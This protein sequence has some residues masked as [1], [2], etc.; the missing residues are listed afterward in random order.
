MTAGYRRLVFCTTL[1]TLAVIVMGAYV[2]LS[3]AGLSCP[4]WPGCYGQALVPSSD[5]QVSLA[6]EAF[7]G[8]PLVFHRA[9]KEMIHR[10]LAGA[11]GIAITLLAVIAYHRRREPRQLVVLP[12]ALVGLVVFQAALGMWTVTLLLKPLVVTA[13]LMGGMTTLALLWWLWLRPNHAGVPVTTGIRTWAF[14]SVV[15]II[16][17]LS[18]GGWTSANYAA[19]ACSEFPT[20]QGSW[21]PEMALGDAFYPW[22]ELGR[23]SDGLP[24][25]SQA[26]VAIQVAHRVG[27]LLALLIVGGFAVV[28]IRGAGVRLRYAAVAVVVLLLIQVGLGVVTV[29]L[30]RPLVFA[31][32]HNAVAALLLSAVLLLARWKTSPVA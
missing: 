17:Q 31:V 12:I 7:P 26:L 5:S 29:L 25:G 3:D 13:H 9:W 1:L 24:L 16:V 23:T 32:A 4:D 30:A 27:A 21:W 2:R 6:N 14:A 15:I 8:R 28:S 20:C 10:Y 19:L 18:L 22:R 11:L